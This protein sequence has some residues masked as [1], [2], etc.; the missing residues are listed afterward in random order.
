MHNLST[1]CNLSGYY[2]NKDVEAKIVFA[3]KIT[4]SIS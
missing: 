1:A 3:K 4:G 2:G